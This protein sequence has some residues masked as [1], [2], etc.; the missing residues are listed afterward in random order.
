VPSY[1][2]D[3]YLGGAEDGNYE[4]GSADSLPA[5]AQDAMTPAPAPQQGMIRLPGG[6]VL[7]KSTA[8]ILAAIAIAIAIWWWQ[9][10][11]KKD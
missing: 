5:V 1:L 7:P 10:S 4:I 6:I 3:T 2:D 9:K 8:I 11:K